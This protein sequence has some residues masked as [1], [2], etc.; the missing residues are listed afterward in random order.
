MD[1]HPR[2]LTRGEAA[3]YCRLSASAFSDWIRRG[4]LPGP[5]SGTTRWDIKAI[6]SALDRA[7]GVIIDSEREDIF[8]VWKR[9]R[10]AKTS[11]WDS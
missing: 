5:I 8:D 6:D 10:Y 1:D 4:L 7:S 11:T 3:A 2:L 9:K